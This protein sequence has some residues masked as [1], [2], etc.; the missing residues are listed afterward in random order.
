MPFPT[1]T[2]T[3]KVSAAECAFTVRST[4]LPRLYILRVAEF[5]WV[6]KRVRIATESQSSFNW[7]ASWIPSIGFINMDTNGQYTILALPRPCFVF[8][9]RFF[10]PG[11]NKG[12]K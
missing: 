11:S 8:V 5:L 9:Q 7:I 6:R 2:R 3:R 10:Q 12:T 4:K 1:C